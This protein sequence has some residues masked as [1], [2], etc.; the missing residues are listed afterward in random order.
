MKTILLA[1]DLHPVL[2][3]A[4]HILN[5][6]DIVVHSAA[7]ADELLMKHFVHRAKLIVTRLD[8]PGMRGERMI[9]V[10]R[11]SDALRSASIMVLFADDPM[12][13]ERSARCGANRVVA[14]PADPALL[15]RHMSQLLNVAPRRAYRVA[16]HMAV[17]G[18]HHSKPIP[19]NSENISPTGILI[20]TNEM[21]APGCKITCSFYLP[22]GT[23]VNAA[24]DVARVVKQ[25]PGATYNQ[26]GVRFISIAPEAAS[27]IDSFVNKYSLQRASQGQ[28]RVRLETARS[29]W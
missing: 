3:P 22:D 9:N 1:T 16:L 19:C 5:C 18:D 23:R 14:L 20:R 26:Y 27:S 7:T 29:E 28:S 2:M 6:S 21:L 11:R 17:N 4:M 12:Q 15:A 10:I 8:L 13:H 25:G 24:G